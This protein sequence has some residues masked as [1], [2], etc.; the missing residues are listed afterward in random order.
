[1]ECFNG[2]PELLQTIVIQSHKKASLAGKLEKLLK[3]NQWKK[4]LIP[5][6][7]SQ[8][9]EDEQELF[10]AQVPNNLKMTVAE[11]EK[12]SQQRSAE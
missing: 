12:A 6:I 9:P 5:A 4:F 2:N 3:Q 1:M 7:T 8:L 10:L 11:L